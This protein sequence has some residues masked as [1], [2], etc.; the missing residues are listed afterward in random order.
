MIDKLI[1]WFAMLTIFMLIVVAFMLV[2]SL[3]IEP[4]VIEVRDD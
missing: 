3:F 1:D 2:A 4:K